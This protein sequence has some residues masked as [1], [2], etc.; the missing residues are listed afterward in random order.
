MGIAFE[1]VEDAEEGDV[2]DIEGDDALAYLY[3]SAKDVVVG[4]NFLHEFG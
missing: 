4:I 1:Y 2:F 3:P